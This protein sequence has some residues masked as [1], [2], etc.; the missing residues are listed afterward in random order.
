MSIQRR[1]GSDSRIEH[2]HVESKRH[3]KDKAEFRDANSLQRAEKML[4]PMDMPVLSEEILR[5]ESLAKCCNQRIGSRYFKLKGAGVV[6]ISG[7]EYKRGCV[8][9]RD[10]RTCY[11]PTPR[12]NPIP[13]PRS[14]RLDV[15]TYGL[16]PAH[17]N[18]LRSLAPEQQIR[19]V[20]MYLVE[21]VAVVRASSGWKCHYI[22]IHD[23]TP[24]LHFDF[25]VTRF[26][27]P[28]IGQKETR[29]KKAASRRLTKR[30]GLGVVG[31][32][33][34]A[35]FRY[36][37]DDHIEVTRPDLQEFAE[38]NLIAYRVKHNY[39]FP[40][41]LNVVLALDNAVRAEFKQ[42]PEWSRITGRTYEVH[43]EIMRRNAT[44]PVRA[45]IA[46]QGIVA[47][48]Q[49]DRDLATFSAEGEAGLEKVRV[50][51][52]AEIK[53][54][55]L[56]QLDAVKHTA[57]EQ[58]SALMAERDAFKSERDGLS[59]RAAAAEYGSADQRQRLHELET[60][61]AELEVIT[62]R[63]QNEVI[64]FGIENSSLAKELEVARASIAAQKEAY[65]Q[66]LARNDSN[67]QSQIHALEDEL[68][69]LRRS[70]QLAVTTII[71][72][73][74]NAINTLEAKI[75]AQAQELA[76]EQA[77]LSDQK[78]E[79]DSALGQAISENANLQRQSELVHQELLAARELNAKIEADSAANKAKLAEMTKQ[80]T[81]I[82][83]ENA[84]LL[85]CQE[86]ADR[87]AQCLAVVRKAVVELSTHRTAEAKKTISNLGQNNDLRTSFTS[88]C[89][90]YSNE[91]FELDKLRS[92]MVDFPKYHFAYRNRSDAELAV[93]K[94][95]Q[96]NEAM[97]KSLDAMAKSLDATAKSLDAEITT[98]VQNE[99][100]IKALEKVCADL[101]TK[102]NSVD[103]AVE[104]AR[105]KESVVVLD[106]N[107]KFLW[108]GNGVQAEQHKI[109][110]RC[111]GPNYRIISG[112]GLP[113]AELKQRLVTQQEAALSPDEREAFEIFKVL[114]RCCE[115]D[116]ASLE[117]SQHSP[118]VRADL[119]NLMKSV[120]PVR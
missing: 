43:L 87:A 72:A 73:H 52:E 49:F 116:D 120:V 109:F 108:Q 83:E 101:T 15:V 35:W 54:D 9:V 1:I 26:T 84:K 85:T 70:G 20:E 63:K 25:A 57:A 65:S 117:V 114:R 22:A 71:Q 42:H 58:V 64:R 31:T 60:Q 8:E 104:N 10:A 37:E 89:D 82:R 21:A 97:A 81:A 17:S 112:H 45:L 13:T 96:E 23:D 67:H 27:A 102:A 105:A 34:C 78:A 110:A 55:L 51:R 47:T 69:G 100:K 90:K 119:P 76:S 30:R 3:E 36:S 75:T 2:S 39:R 53:H 74:N 77:R 86:G 79:F 32:V 103:A 7:E 93:P 80:N 29:Q 91:R 62:Q 28:E 66:A 113:A 115:K 59:D 48:S 4:A 88:L 38:R 5:D 16:L 111:A 106:R 61:F 6:E 40:T 12:A 18:F 92:L 107:W 94:L 56:Q 33:S 95:R 11:R 99:E 68:E 19:S 14:G 24:L 118:A 41:D 50:A 46:R 98:A 44:A